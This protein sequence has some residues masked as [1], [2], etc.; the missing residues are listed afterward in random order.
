MI[1]TAIRR[2]GLVPDGALKASKPANKIFQAAFGQLKSRL[3]FKANSQ[4]ALKRL[5]LVRHCP[6]TKIGH[7]NLAYLR[8]KS[9][10]AKSAMIKRSLFGRRSLRPKRLGLI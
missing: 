2:Y 9:L 6:K 7:E 3:G 8:P 5:F 10:L 1:L 4:A